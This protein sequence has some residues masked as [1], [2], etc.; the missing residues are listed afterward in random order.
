MK[1]FKSIRHLLALVVVL[2]LMLSTSAVV[3]AETGTVTVNGG[4]LSVSPANISFTGVTLSG[5]DQTTTSAAQDPAW[6]AQDSRGTGA[7]WNL[8]ISSADFTTDDVQQVYNDATSGN[9][10]M[11]YSGQTTTAID[12]NATAAVVETAVE[13]LSNVTAATV[14][15]SGT[16]SIPW[17]IRFVTDTGSG[18][19]TA[20]DTNLVGGT[21][22]IT[23]A[24]IDISEADQLFRIQLTEG[25]IALVEGNAKPTTSVAAL[26]SI[27]DSTV[28]FLSAATDTGMGSYTLAPNFNLAVPAE[29]YAA[30]YTTTITV[31]AVTAP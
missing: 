24:T 27:A 26:T 13:G 3:Y 7:G 31:T 23:L 18:I 4:T 8:T 10:T 30:T 14:T 1:K 20:D 16:S 29:V 2:A 11:T 21:S 28:K 19:V 6:T 12:Y 22:T 25:N 15:G 9:F 5:A 17:V